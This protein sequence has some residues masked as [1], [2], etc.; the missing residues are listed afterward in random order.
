LCGGAARALRCRSVLSQVERF[1]EIYLAAKTQLDKERMKQRI[2]TIFQACLPMNRKCQGFL[3]QKE[4]L[5][6]KK[7]GEQCG[8]PWGKFSNSFNGV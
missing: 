1:I 2:D 8:Q 6:Q 4:I 5:P 3:S 7:R